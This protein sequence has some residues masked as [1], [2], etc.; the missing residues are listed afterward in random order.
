MDKKEKALKYFR[1]HYNCSQSVFTVFGTED[2]LT[3]DQCLRAA[4]GFGGGMG[5]MQVTCG[6]VTGAVMALGMKHGKAFG[7]PEEKKT[8]TYARTRE[9][10]A[11]FEK[12]HG[13]TVCRQLL[14]GLN[15]ND[16]EELARIKELGLFEKNCERYISDAVDITEKLI[17]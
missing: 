4:C 1:D 17:K 12:L 9:L 16:P 2:G 10:F 7:D 8:D 6:A 3:E 11:E 15:M 5:R 13:T 14:N